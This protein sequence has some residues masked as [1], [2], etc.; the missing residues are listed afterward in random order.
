MKK[1]IALI[2][3]NITN[4]GGTERVIA[5]FCNMLAGI[6]DVKIYSLSTK[7]GDCFYQIDNRVS[8][9]HMGM[10]G[11]EH[12]N[13]AIRK[14]MLRISS[15]VGFYFF[16]RKIDCDFLIGV[17]KNINLMLAASLFFRKKERIIGWEHF[18]YNAPMSRIVGIIRTFIY[19]RL[20]KLV[21]LT[22][23][24]YEYYTIHN[25]K[26]EVIPNSISPLKN[27]NRNYSSKIILAVGRHT[28]QKRFD[29]LL[30][31]WKK[32]DCKDRE[33]WVL[34]IIGDG[35]LL[36]QNR[37]IAA[38]LGVEESVKFTLPTKHIA[39]EYA[40]SSFLVMTSAYE[41]FPMVLL[42]ALRSGLP[43][44]AYDCDTGPRDIIV[45]GEDGFVIP[46]GDENIFVNAMKKLINDP[47]LRFDMG[48]KAKLNVLRFGDE[49]IKNK[50][51]KLLETL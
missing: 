24:D 31:I 11:Y 3:T 8:I 20:N 29:R 50:W 22:Q 23:F 34:N 46:Y 43:C 4:S 48:E 37:K 19:K 32:I 15:V 49:S 33:G 1:K 47:K 2:T 42:E 35:P 41:A 12:V 13:S 38:D 14:N 45:S 9:V 40:S 21:V 16:L 17:N 30:N 25:I 18:A 28:Q 6:Y 39:L 27:E 44:L 10:Q 26:T 36:A 51:I 5:N 7:C